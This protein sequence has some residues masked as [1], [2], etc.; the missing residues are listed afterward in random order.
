MKKIVITSVIVGLVLLLGITTLILGLVPV[1]MNDYVQL[2]NTVY[3]YCHKTSD[4]NAKKDVYKNIEN[5][6]ESDVEKIYKIY[7]LFNNS[8]Q[9]KALSALF[10]G[11]IKNETKIVRNEKGVS[12]T[13][14]KNRSEDDEN[15]TL[16]FGYKNPQKLV[17]NGEEIEYSYLFFEI[18]S[19]DEMKNVIMGVR[20]EDPAGEDGDEELETI[21]YV[22]SY[23]TLANFSQLY[24]YVDGIVSNKK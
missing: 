8:F 20:T 24:S 23:Q 4:L 15:I 22:Y 7:N 11:Q 1:G 6:N 18:S 10:N 2:P 14:S 12:Q 3:V 19:D 21:A 9:Q 5:G 13:I 17:Y 16:V